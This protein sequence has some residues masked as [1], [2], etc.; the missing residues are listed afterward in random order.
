MFSQEEQKYD[1]AQ[2]LG[3]LK[4]NRLKLGAVTFICAVASAIMTFFI[5]KEYSSTAIIF[6][7][8]H[9]SLDFN[10]DNP[11]FG[12]D[13]EADRLL[14]I[15]QSKEIRDSVSNKFDLLNYYKLDKTTKDWLDRLNK[16]YKKDVIFERTQYMSIKVSAQ[17]TDPEMSANM[18]NYILRIANVVREKIYK[19]NIVLAYNKVLQEYSGEKKITDSLLAILQT[20]FKNLNISSL[21]L[22][23]PNTQLSFNFEQVSNIKNNGKENLELGPAILQYRHHL[24]KYNDF[25]GRLKKTRKMLESPISEIYVVDRA[26]PSYRKVSPSFTINTL[27]AAFVGFLITALFLGLRRQN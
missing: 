22:L 16:R 7:P 9:L 11:N 26:E 15:L 24:E 25:E 21:V 6:P 10:I 3:F 18:V 2:L 17:T 19:Q 27:A 23:A 5:P 1:L 8:A 12:Y 4:A 14:Q 20:D 13:V